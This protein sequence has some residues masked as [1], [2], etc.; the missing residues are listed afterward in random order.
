MPLH[1]R[2]LEAGPGLRGSH[3]TADA[4]VGLVAP[5]GGA[6]F[7]H[8]HLLDAISAVYKCGRFSGLAA[9]ETLATGCNAK[10]ALRTALLC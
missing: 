8:Q 1:L 10:I 2:A 9:C 4:V 3:Q 5:K 6:A 7:E